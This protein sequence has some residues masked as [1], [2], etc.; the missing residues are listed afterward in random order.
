MYN[1]YTNEVGMTVPT[2]YVL[3]LLGVKKG[4]L[5][6]QI[7]PLL[8]MEAGSITRLLKSMEEQQLILRTADQED[9]RQVSVY[10]TDAGMKKRHL[11][12][13][14]VAL[15]NDKLSQEIRPEKLDNFLTVL[16]QIVTIAEQNHFKEETL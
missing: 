12:R 1:S 2:A 3:L 8:G 7:A 9:K 5:S 10:L 11:A 4:T 14:I 16:D 15:F 6:T 13:K